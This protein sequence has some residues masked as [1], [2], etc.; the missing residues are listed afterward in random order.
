MDEELWE[1]TFAEFDLYLDELSVRQLQREA[2][3]AIST[4]PADNNSIH[5]FNTKA[6]HNSHL[7][8]KA[9][10]IHYVMEHGD[11]PSIVGPGKEVRFVLDEE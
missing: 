7:W 1:L 10:I 4:M 5:K 2:A 8:Y 3:R 11:L 9:V 6:H